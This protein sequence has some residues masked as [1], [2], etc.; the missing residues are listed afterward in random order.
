MALWT[1]RGRGLVFVERLPGPDLAR[2][3]REAPPPTAA[4]RT[5]ARHLGR[6]VGRVHGFGLRNR[7]L[8]LENLVRDPATGVVSM[9]DL[10][11]I[12]RRAPG[13]SRGAGRDLGRLLAAW[14]ALGRRDEDA[15]VRSFWAGYHRARRCLGQNPPRRLR[16]RIEER[17]REWLAA[18]PAA[19]AA[20]GRSDDA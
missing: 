10:D 12:R 17:A 2:E 20:R 8:K 18:H 15:V 4:L 19:T 6:A 16:R 11:G 13:E 14:R 1:A 7:D 5:A 3:L 9:V